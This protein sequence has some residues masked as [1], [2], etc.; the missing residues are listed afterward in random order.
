MYEKGIIIPEA[1]GYPVQPYILDDDGR[2]IAQPDEIGY[3][4][5]PRKEDEYQMFTTKEMNIIMDEFDG[6]CEL[7]VDEQEYD[8]D[9][10]QPVY[11]D[12]LVVI[13]GLTPDEDDEP[14]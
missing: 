14:D 4:D 7:L 8:N 2:Q 5:N 1:F 11:V 3:F 6:L 13:R 9:F 10:I 12:D